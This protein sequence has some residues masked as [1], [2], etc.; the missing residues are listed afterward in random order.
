M[1]MRFSLPLPALGVDEEDLRRQRGKGAL[2]SSKKIIEGAL[3]R[4]RANRAATDFSLSAQHFDSGL[5]KSE[6][7]A[8]LQS[9]CILQD[10]TADV[11]I[12]ATCL[13][14]TWRTA[15]APGGTAVMRG[16]CESSPE[17]PGRGNVDELTPPEETLTAQRQQRG[18]RVACLDGE[19]VEAGLAGAGSGEEGLAAAGRAVEKDPCGWL[20]SEASQGVAV[21]ERPLYRL[22]E[23][24]WRATRAAGVAQGCFSCCSSLRTVGWKEAVEIG[25]GRGGGGGGRGGGGGGGG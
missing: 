23:A 18:D 7:Y 2:A 22:L 10:T 1:R 3:V 4:A 8:V 15:P 16:S 6:G 14:P 13:R 21:L 25:R 12:P 24:L 5:S 9:R 11:Q 17:S 20:G 19:E